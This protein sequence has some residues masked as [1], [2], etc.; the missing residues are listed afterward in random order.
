MP[1][2][3]Y[4]LVDSLI[5]GITERS[6]MSQAP[7]ISNCQPQVGGRPC[8]PLKLLDPVSRCQSPGESVFEFC[9]PWGTVSILFCNLDRRRDVISGFWQSHCWV[10]EKVSAPFSPG[11]GRQCGDM[12]FKDALPLL[13]V[14]PSKYFGQWEHI[15][16][17]TQLFLQKK[18]HMHSKV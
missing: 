18:T 13:S 10:S 12:P 7:W 5:L 16:N 17:G 6:H 1:G 14:I 2:I 9:S 15:G 3:L 11:T 8:S 4:K